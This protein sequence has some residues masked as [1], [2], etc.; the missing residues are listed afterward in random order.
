VIR[1]I[2]VAR[3]NVRRELA[4]YASAAGLTLLLLSFGA[5]GVTPCDR[6][7]LLRVASDVDHPPQAIA[8]PNVRSPSFH[9]K[10]SPL[11]ERVT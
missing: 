9:V 3:R 11:L 7:R 2:A 8:P 5:V 4:R 10:H 6:C 1:P